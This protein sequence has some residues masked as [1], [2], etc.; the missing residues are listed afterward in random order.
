MWLFNSSDLLTVMIVRMICRLLMLIEVY[1]GSVRLWQWS[2]RCVAPTAFGSCASTSSS[3]VDSYKVSRPDKHVNV[4][5][6][7]VN[8][9]EFYFTSSTDKWNT[10]IW[11]N[12][13]KLEFLR[14]SYFEKIGGSRR[15][16]GET[17]S[18]GPTYESTRSTIKLLPK[19]S[20]S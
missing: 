9:S 18:Y 13:E 7:T 14:L 20:F 10:F 17:L 15:A 6:L 4:Q 1:H 5:F 19:E 3:L 2:I 11:A 12:K 16:D 8:F